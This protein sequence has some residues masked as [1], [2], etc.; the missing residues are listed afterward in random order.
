M[1]AVRREDRGRHSGKEEQDYPQF[2]SIASDPRQHLSLPVDLWMTFMVSL[3]LS[4]THRD[5]YVC[6]TVRVVPASDSH[7]TVTVFEALRDAR[8]QEEPQP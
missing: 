7:S 8:M 5:R 2:V 4:C 6:S 3:V 1:R